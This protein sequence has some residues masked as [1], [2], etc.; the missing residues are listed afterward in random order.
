MEEVCLDF[1]SSQLLYCA[2]MSTFH[3]LSPPLIPGRAC[4]PRDVF[5]GGRTAFPNGGSSPKECDGVNETRSSQM[6]PRLSWKEGSDIRL[7]LSPI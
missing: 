1:P 6:F 4:F 2:S 5:L 7:K 3:C